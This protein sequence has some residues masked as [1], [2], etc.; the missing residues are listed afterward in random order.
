MLIKIKKEKKHTISP[1]I[2]MQFAEPLGT[3]DSSVDAGWDF[4]HDRWQPKLVEKV[5][6]LAP[7][8]IRWG[9]CFASYYHW[10]EAVG[11]QSER[12]PMLNL[13][14]DGIYSNMVGTGEVVDLCKEA[15]AE[16]LLVVNME[17]D[18]RLHWAYPK[19]GMNRL[20]TAEEAAEWV[21]YCNNPNNELRLSHGVT[22]PYNVR[23]W[24]IG[25]ETSYDQRGFDMEVA[26]QKTLEFARK[27]RK[28][29][30]TIRL[31]AWGDNGWAKRM[32]EVAGD[33][34]DYIAFHYHF[35]NS[36]LP[37]CPLNDKEYRKDPDNTWKHLMNT[38]KSLEAYIDTMRE[39][40]KPYGK[41]LAMTEGHY[42]L[43]GRDRCDVLST[44]GAGV[45]YARCLNVLERAT[46]VLDIATLADFFG[47][48]WQVNALML[49]TPDRLGPAY[50]QPVGEVMRLFRHHIG[51][52][53][54]DVEKEVGQVDLTASLSEDE[55]TVYLHAVNTDRLSDKRLE[56]CFEGKTVK[57]IKAFTIAE[58]AMTE[59]TYQ[60]TDVFRPRESEVEGNTFI[61]PAAG[62]SSLEIELE[63]QEIL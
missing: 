45:S 2:F 48:R 5:K 41:R 6:E 44:W 4:L 56:I 31:L 50:L 35:S 61:L 23:F 52:Y 18:G 27:M 7:T 21:D 11:P 3:A 8:M 34:I 40:V 13:C 36:G 19:E 1:Y 17:S 33:E 38:C 63:E 51:M 24:Q 47:N 54:L 53:A 57:K 39:Q 29:D 37:D 12:V 42:V 26:A 49:C 22:E 58:D 46:D 55:K 60:N 10:K 28:A 62:V 32:C 59:I 9:G 30:P 20:G 14:W 25:N 15:G 43:A 16:P